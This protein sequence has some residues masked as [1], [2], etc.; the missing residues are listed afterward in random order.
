MGEREQFGSGPLWH[1]ALMSD[2]CWQ[3][4]VGADTLC[5]VVCYSVCQW[6]LQFKDGNLEHFLDHKLHRP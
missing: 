2:S 6:R 4:V 1:P 5:V 3:G